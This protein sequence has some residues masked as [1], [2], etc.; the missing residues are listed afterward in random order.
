MDDEKTS[1]AAKL[2]EFA[3]T[4]DGA[5]RDIIEK[6]HEEKERLENDLRQEYRNARKYVRSHPEESLAY[7]FIGGVVAGLLLARFF[8]R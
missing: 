8:S 3:G 7:A 4:H 1:K 5:Y 6:L 2:E